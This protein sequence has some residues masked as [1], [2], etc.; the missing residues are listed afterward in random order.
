MHVSD[1]ADCTQLQQ[2]AVC[3][4][5][6]LF[7]DTVGRSAVDCLPLEHDDGF[8]VVRQD[9]VH[10]SHIAISSGFT[11]GL[12]TSRACC[13]TDKD[14]RWL[15]LTSEQNSTTLHTLCCVSM[16][17]VAIILYAWQHLQGLGNGRDRLLIL[18]WLPTGSHG[19]GCNW[20][21]GSHN[22][23]AQ[24]TRA[25]SWHACAVRIWSAWHP[26][27]FRYAQVKEERRYLETNGCLKCQL[28]TSN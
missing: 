23:G 14:E 18:E 24:T 20:T 22:A 1:C 16:S 2:G 11:A 3:V 10:F 17:R 8:Q 9:S 25:Q 19:P 5:Q 13:A 12:S 6:V 28:Q 15:R 26:P 27:S 7:C 4:V 21:A